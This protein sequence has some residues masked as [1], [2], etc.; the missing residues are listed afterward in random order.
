MKA[1]EYY[2]SIKDAIET[3]DEMMLKDAVDNMFFSMNKEVRSLI[4]IRNVSLDRGAGPIIKE[5]ND[6]WNAVCRLAEKDYG[7][8]PIHRDGYKKYWLGLIPELRRYI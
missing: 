2:A 7:D 8:S 6:K 5:M 3:H 4:K 1:K